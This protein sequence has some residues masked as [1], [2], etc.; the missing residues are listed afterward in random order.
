MGYNRPAKERLLPRVAS[1]GPQIVGT[2]TWDAARVLVNWKQVNNVL[3]KKDALSLAEGHPGP[4][5]DWSQCPPF[6]S[7]PCCSC[8]YIFCWLEVIFPYCQEIDIVLNLSIESE[9]TVQEV[10]YFVWTTKL[11][12]LRF[13]CM[14]V[15]VSISLEIKCHWLFG[16]S[17]GSEREGS[18]TQC[19]WSWITSLRAIWYR[20][21]VKTILENQGWLYVNS[22]IYKP[23]RLYAS[24][25]SCLFIL[26]F[27]LFERPR[28]AQLCKGTQRKWALFK[29]RSDFSGWESQW[30]WVEQKSGNQRKPTQR[31][32]DLEI[33]FLEPK[34]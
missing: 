24:C 4:V 11:R 30:R 10:A 31:T 8:E 33:F 26:F 18:W 32:L 25:V 13:G 5:T 27:L 29:L 15:Q 22:A 6:I 12:S 28:L 34:P 9:V 7:H 23:I 2:P 14:E 20:K 21:G 16:M 17:L 19:L 1:Q 3:F